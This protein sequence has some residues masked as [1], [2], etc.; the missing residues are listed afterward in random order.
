MADKNKIVIPIKGDTK[1]FDKK[2]S[3]SESRVKR[4]SAASKNIGKSF[5]GATK[6]AA[7]GFLALTAIVGKSIDVFKEQEQVEL[8]TAATIEATGKA[9]GLTAEEIFEMASALQE[10]TTV[11][12]E[13]I[14]GGQNLLL[15]FRNI[16]GDI[17]PRAT[18]AMLDMSA[19]MGTGL[20]GSAVQLGK[21]LNDPIKGIAALGRAGITFTDSQKEQIKTM[22]KAGD[23]AGAQSV[24]LSE[25]EN[26][27]G[28]L[29]RAAAQGTGGLT[30]TSNILGDIVE[31]IGKSALPFVGFLNTKIKAMAIAFQGTTA[32]MDAFKDALRGTL[33]IGAVVKASFS[34][35]GGILGSVAAT[36]AESAA[37]LA[38]GEFKRALEITKQGTGNIKEVVKSA[39]KELD[40]DLLAISNIGAARVKTQQEEDLAQ[41]KA[42]AVKKKE[43]A[44]AAEKEKQEAI[45]EAKAVAFEEELA[46]AEEEATLFDEAQLARIEEAAAKEQMARDIAKAEQ[47]KAEGKHQQAMELLRKTQEKR[48]I[49]ASKRKIAL[50]KT[51]NDNLIKDR[52][53]F[54]NTAASLQ[55]SEN[56]KLAMIGKA[57]ALLQIAIAT[58]PAVASSFRFGASIGGPPLGVAFAGIAATAMAAQAAQVA[59]ITGFAEGGMVTGGT[60]GVDSVNAKV[61][62]GEVI[63]PPQT[64][65]RDLVDAGRSFTTDGAE[66]EEAG[67]GA[68]EVTI[69]FTDNAFD[70]IEEKILERR[71]LGIGSI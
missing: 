13:A 26:Q 15:T 68:M 64:T 8:K 24:V 18:E 45:R 10:V 62:Q 32:P 42:N 28:G 19:A 1:E 22:Q 65:F 40:D 12:D 51:T 20:K 25:L 33:E 70:I 34:T 44:L 39:A 57:A 66:S 69:G 31:V 3:K 58:P 5:A 54:L 60:P 67:A 61:Q 48:D 37:A 59:G 56:K 53:A 36:V 11:G 52:E 27:F 2:I 55:S 14:I 71:T 6:I 30:Q 35:I 63:V 29:A 49:D 17:F 23:I 4:L 7:T 38:A 46:A 9:A 50:E 47:L 43:I 16:G 21:A 41:I